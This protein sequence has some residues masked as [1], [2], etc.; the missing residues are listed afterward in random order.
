[1]PP[2]VSRMMLRSA[3]AWENIGERWFTTFAGV[4]MVEASKQIYAKPAPM[5]RAPRARP[6]YIPIG[7]GTPSPIGR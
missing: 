3:P 4:S 7:H 6:V 2:T 5:R 1:M